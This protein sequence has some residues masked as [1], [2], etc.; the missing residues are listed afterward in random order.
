MEMDPDNQSNNFLKGV[1]SYQIN[2]CQTIAKHVTY[3]VTF[4]KVNG[5]IWIQVLG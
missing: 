5:M 4:Y 1:W 2:I 3:K